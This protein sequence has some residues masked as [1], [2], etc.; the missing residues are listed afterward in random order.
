MSMQSKPLQSDI[1]TVVKVRFWDQEITY[2]TM[3]ITCIIIIAALPTIFA[4]MTTPDDRFFTSVVY[5]IPDH[6][7]YFAWLRD[8]QHQ[9]LAAN[10][11]TAEPNEPALFH[12]LWWVSGKFSALFNLS[13]S[14]IFNILRI[15]GGITLLITGY[16]FFRF[17]IT[18]PVQ[19]KL[20]FILFATGGGLGIIWVVIKYIQ[21]LEEVPFP[22]DIYTSEPNS[23][24]LAL[25]FPH[26][27]IALSLI[28]GVIGFTLLAYQ[29]QQLRYAV[30]AG[31]CGFLIGL[32]HA[33]DILTI[34]AVLGTFGI[35]IWWR[36][37]RF[38]TFLFQCGIIIAMFTVPP[39]AYLSWLV[40]ND[41]TWGGKLAQFDNAGAWTPNLLHLPILLGVPFL[42]ALASFRP[43]ML[44]S[45]DNTELL[46]TAWFLVHFVLAY[47]PVS[48]Q[49]H[50]LLGWQVP[51]AALAARF[52][53]TNLWPWARQRFGKMGV[54]TTTM[55]ILALAMITNIYLVA[56]RIVDLGRYQQ[57]YFLSSDE[58]AALEWLANHTT[59]DD[60][61]LGVLEINQHVPPW[62]DAHAFLAHWAG[63]LD[64]YA[65]ID[66]VAKVLDPNTPS[67]ERNAIL[68]MYNV[69][70]I[71]VREQDVNRD[72]FNAATNSELTLV[73]NQGSVAIYQY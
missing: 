55:A 38:P 28:I 69:R 36:D 43:R 63:S 45:Q 20:A 32:Q 17:T 44:R 56:W 1:H 39:G 59:K 14:V 22:F 62:T 19:R 4:Y 47:L 40:L 24:F 70:Y 67:A 13:F 71:I 42:L 53:H 3:F 21:Q 2:I 23:F 51:I 49:I 10:R 9:D 27:A 34:A 72:Q 54:I 11:L 64:Y 7:Q 61:V 60:V 26:F 35:L 29:R 18:H 5:N 37:R 6:N 12:L 15:I 58:V 8:F 46:F 31:I 68:S 65:K 66:M 73:F 33:Y 16:L 57:P 25:A 52:I 48:F 30:A 41:V 50:L